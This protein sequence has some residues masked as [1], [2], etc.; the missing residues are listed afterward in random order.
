MDT[1]ADRLRRALVDAFP[2]YLRR[3]LAEIDAP[4]IDP[5]VVA[6]AERLDAELGDLLS[7]PP[8]AQDRSPLQVVRDVLAEPTS[9]LSALGVPGVDRD[10]EQEALL[11]GDR[12]G[13]A[14]ATARDLGDEAWQAH[15]AWGVAKAREVAGMVPATDRQE[16]TGPLVALVST[17][18]MDRSKLSSVAESAGY[19]V[20]V[21]RNP[22][23]VTDLLDGRRPVVAFVDL[24]HSA[25]DEAMRLL[26]AGGVRIVAYGPHVDDVALARARSLGAAEAL[27]RSRFFHDPGRYLPPIV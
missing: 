1:E 23:A 26:A 27:P 17:E 7:R 10:P 24:S 8:A 16:P 4:A 13:L 12:Y 21:T 2:S 20:A 9:A 14:P 19:A 6:A 25:A 3:R 15:L 22:A 11:P 5:A 18:L